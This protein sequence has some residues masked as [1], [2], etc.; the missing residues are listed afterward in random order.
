MAEHE[1]FSYIIMQRPLYS[2]NLRINHSHAHYFTAALRV[3]EGTRRAA[4]RKSG[5]KEVTLSGWR[6]KREEGEGGEKGGR[7]DSIKP[8]PAGQL[9]YS[10][11]PHFVGPLSAFGGGSGGGAGFSP[12]C[13]VGRRGSEAC[14]RLFL[15]SSSL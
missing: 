4:E 13:K 8:E 5:F 10:T 6:E 9:G 1:I 15:R 7:L 12:C 3:C 2:T 14:S 11:S